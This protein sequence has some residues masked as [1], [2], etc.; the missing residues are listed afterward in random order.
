MTQPASFALRSLQLHA[1]TRLQ[2]ATIARFFEAAIPPSAQQESILRLHLVSLRG[3]IAVGDRT[4]DAICRSTGSTLRYLN[5]DF[6]DVTADSVAAI[7]KLAPNLH[8][9]KLGYNENLSD[10]TLQVALQAPASGALPFSKLVNLRLRQCSQV[11]DA[12]VAGFLKYTHKTLEVLDI[13]GTGVGGTNPHNP[14]FHILL[15]FLFPLGVLGGIS[16]HGAH[17]AG[18]TSSSSS[19]LALR[20]LNLLD[21]NIDYESLIKIVDRAPDMDTLL[22]RQTPSRTTRDGMI[23]LLEKLTSA[24]GDGGWQNR[25]WKRLHLRIL[26]VGDEF[27]DLFPHLLTIFPRLHLDSLESSQSRT[28]FFCD[29]PGRIEPSETIVQHLKL[30]DA[31]LSEHTWQFLPL[32]TS[33]HTLDLSNTAVPES[34]VAS[35]I[36]ANPFLELIDLLHCKQMR[37]STR[38]NAFSLV[39]S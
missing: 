8:T 29:V 36:E 11:A 20:K 2:D 7:M 6:T 26:D 18:S 38:R 32:I 12:G 21:T 5:L 34:I 1:L 30:P 10:K 39:S 13:S 28:S 9:L 15:T 3:C 22:L 19:T 31:R 27:A 14:D 16:E 23:N 35:T 37:V 25:S 17:F 33:L 4:V 24:P